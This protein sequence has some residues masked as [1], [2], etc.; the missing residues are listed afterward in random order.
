MSR[1]IGSWCTVD[2]SRAVFAT[3]VKKNPSKQLIFTNT[4]EKKHI[5][6]YT[7]CVYGRGA[8]NI[9]KRRRGGRLE[10]CLGIFASYNTKG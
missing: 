4:G 5:F 9:D 7:K 2:V 6:P 3:P 8:F 10:E 1:A